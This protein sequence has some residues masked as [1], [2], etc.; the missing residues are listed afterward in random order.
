MINSISI[1]FVTRDPDLAGQVIG[2]IR[3][4]GHAV[5]PK[6]TGNLRD[7]DRLLQ[8]HR[9]DAVVLIDSGLEI[10][11]AEVGEAL[12]RAGRQTP[13][14]L[15]SDHGQEQSLRAIDSGIFA[16]VDRNSDDLAAV[17]TLRAVEHLNKGREITHLRTLL[18]EADRRFLLML[19]T[20]RYPI[21]CFHEGSATYANE[22]WRDFFEMDLSESIDGLTLQ[23]LVM[24]EQQE[25]LGE[26]LTELRN[27]PENAETCETLTVRTRRGRSFDADLV[28]ASAVI[29]GEPSI[30]VHVSVAGE[31][32]ALS[33]SGSLSAPS[34]AA[35]NVGRLEQ[36]ARPIN[37][38]GGGAPATDPRINAGTARSSAPPPPPAAPPAQP[39]EPPVAPT[40]Q[41]PDDGESERSFLRD[42]D[43]QIADTARS[44]RTLALMTFTPD[45]IQTGQGQRSEI[46]GN[47]LLDLLRTQFPAPAQVSRLREGQ[48]GIVVPNPAR[49]ALEQ[50]IAAALSAAASISLTLG[51]GSNVPGTLSCGAVLTD[52]SG[53]DANTLL[54]QAR[55]ALA[56]ART[57]GGNRHQFHAPPSA[58]GADAQA[59]MIWKSRIEQAVRDNRL[60]LLFQPIV[61]LQ[62][63]DIPRYNV[64]LRLLG[65]EGQVYEPNEFL[66]PAERT[67]SAAPLDRWVIQQAAG[68]LAEEIKRDER[69][70]FFL[71]L[72]QGSLDGG[73][74]VEWLERSLERHKVPAKNVVVEFREATLLTQPETAAT[75]AEGI[76]K[77]GAGLCIGDFGNGLEPFKI[78]KLVD[79]AY[80]R[81]D[82]AFANRLAQDPE[83]Q[84]AVR[85]LTEAAREQNRL[86]IMPMVEDAATLT[87]LFAM[88][89]NLVQGYFV[90]PP[91]EQLGF[92]FASGL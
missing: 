56:Q 70:V 81:L 12:H 59:E 68:M 15:I 73:S 83:T 18:R 86:V 67:G 75:M 79:A 82:G 38:N 8:S 23:D 43:T 5:R 22:V 58:P 66:P 71:K 55:Q 11:L 3:Y 40:P 28:L 57:A 88:E 1:L 45:A 51:D 42:A 4:R 49:A 54:E 69:S 92:D 16:V 44:G 62:G 32:P 72:S 80:I 36:P 46:P 20:S 84:E 24:P 53:P 33:G 13:I 19:D 74:V 78:L 60:R 85:E 47:A 64:F 63:E 26:I 39:A 90:Q 2:R 6:Q 91:S 76:R 41:R 17:M 48:I 30:V 87:A 21:A 27:Q 35:P 34:A 77:L 9:F 50:Q 14:V 29:N 7:L 52:D 65:E 61:N 25:D 10:G 89:V 31:D 37:T